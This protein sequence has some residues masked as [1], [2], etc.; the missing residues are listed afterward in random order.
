MPATHQV[1][2]E[3]QIYNDEP[4]A[5]MDET[6]RAEIVAAILAVIQPYSGDGDVRTMAYIN[7]YDTQE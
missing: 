1:N 4:A 3:F 5:D 6:K 2:G 7:W